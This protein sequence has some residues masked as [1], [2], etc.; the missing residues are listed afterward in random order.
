MARSN[1]G[2]QRD[3]FGVVVKQFKS[4]AG[5]RCTLRLGKISDRNALRFCEKLEQFVSTVGAGQPL[6]PELVAWL[7]KLSDEHKAKLAGWGLYAAQKRVEVPT[8]GAFVE[9]YVTLRTD[10][11]GGTATFYGHTKRNLIAFFGADKRL[12][13]ITAGDADEFRL[14][15]LKPKDAGGQELS[16]ATTKRRCGM[17]SQF[18]RAAVRK[19]FIDRNPFE[20][21]GGVVKS[22]KARQYFVPYA[23]AMKIIEA[24]PDNE[25]RLIVALSRFGGLRTPSEHYGLRWDGIDWDRGRMLVRS[26]KTEHHEGGDERWVPIFPEI[27]PYLDRAWVE[28]QELESGSQ[29]VL[30]KY[31]NQ[32]NLRTRFK[33]IITRAG[34]IP[35]Q[36]LFQNLRSTRQT[37]LAAKYPLHVVCAWLGNKAAV[38]AEH[39]LQTTEADFARAVANPTA[40]L[41][42]VLHTGNGA[43]RLEATEKGCDLAEVSASSGESFPVG[44]NDSDSVGNTGCESFAPSTVK[45]RLSTRTLAPLLPSNLA[46]RLLCHLGS[47]TATD[48]ELARLLAL[49]PS[50]P[51]ADRR[52]VVSLA[53]AMAEDRARATAEASPTTD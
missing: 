31:R 6:D 43:S 37:E 26:P 35:W 33:K 24:C 19:E 29:F 50:L 16:E 8:V 9:N 49:W 15:L 13:E 12:A 48:P 7:E 47:D 36:K 14:W 1:K 45:T 11:K 18:F 28:W 44:E 25:W 51:P 40:T 30:A 52:E 3:K 5:E 17:A 23:D 2:Y 32:A 41:A 21:T 42:P 27:R 4:P 22:N 10:V 53:E 46:E 20:G 34:L 39:Y 38:A